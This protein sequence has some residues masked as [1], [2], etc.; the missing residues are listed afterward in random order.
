M[1]EIAEPLRRTFHAHTAHRCAVRVALHRRAA[2]RAGIRQAERYGSLRPLREINAEDFRNDLPCLSH[3]DRIADAN[4]ELIDKILIVERRRRDGRTGK[5]HRLHNGFRRQ[6]AGPADLHDNVAHYRGLLLR[7]VFIRH[8]PARRLGGAAENFALRKVVD[9]DDSAVNIKG[10]ALARI[11]DAPNLLAALLHGA[12]HLMRHRIK[13]ELFQHIQRF[14][15][16]FRLFAGGELDIENDDVEL[17]F[18]GHLRVQL[19]HGSGRGVARIGEE[20]FALDLAAAVMLKKDLPSH[21]HLAP[22]DQPLGRVFQLERY[23]AQDA[24]ILRYVLARNAVAARCALIEDAVPVFQRHRKPVDFRLDRIE[25][26]AAERFVRLADEVG[27][28]LIGKNV[29]ERFKRNGVVHGREF[30]RTV[31]ADVLRRRVRRNGLRVLRFQIFQTAHHR[32][33]LKVRNR[34]GILVVIGYAVAAQ[35]FAELGDLL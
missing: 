32:V 7:R 26:F 27:Q 35:L 5:T 14:R 4:I 8:R 16:C 20:R 28:L 9:L 34:G 29:A 1:D 13:S 10:I 19:T 21:I 11:A 25:R 15:V 24:K 23:I 3:D 33:I 2:L 12:E 30:L 6:N 31:T 18:F 17:A 22:D